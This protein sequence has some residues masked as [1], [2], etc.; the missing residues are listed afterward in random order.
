[1]NIEEIRNE[2]ADCNEARAHKHRGELLRELDLALG[3]IRVLA[4]R[5]GFIAD[6][7]A[8]GG[9]VITGPDATNDYLERVG[10]SVHAAAM[11]AADATRPS[12]EAELEARKATARAERQWLAAQRE[13][14]VSVILAA[15]LRND[16][17]AS[18]PNAELTREAL[19]LSDK[20]R[21]EL[22]VRDELVDAK[23]QL[24]EL[25]KN[26]PPSLSEYARGMFN[27]YNATPPNPGLSWD[28]RPVPKWEDLNE[29]VQG[30]WAGAAMFM[31]DA[32]T[33]VE[34]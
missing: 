30:K 10:K 29:Q 5:T 11:A 24:A 21:N 6:R 15:L 34:P 20:L 8:S 23:A 14:N 33:P 28:G 18:F 32:L 27:A 13:A 1:M 19:E 17:G 31:I 2:H 22:A 3:A 7:D 25:K 26:P 12:P 16:G 4:H 9:W